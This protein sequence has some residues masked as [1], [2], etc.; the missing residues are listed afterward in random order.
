MEDGDT[1]SYELSPEAVTIDLGAT[2]NTDV[3]GNTV[4]GLQGTQ[5]DEDSYA[6]G[7]I[8]VGIENVMGSDENDNITGDANA[9]RLMGG[10]GNDELTGVGGA[11]TLMGG[12]G[13]DTLTGGA[14]DDKLMGGADDDILV[15]G[16]GNDMFYGGA[17]EDQM[18]AASGDTDIF[19][20]SPED[21]AGHDIINSF[22]ANET[23]TTNRIDLRAF[24]LDEDDLIPLI[25]FRGGSVRIDLRPFGGGTIEVNGAGSLDAV[26]TVDA[27]G[28]LTGLSVWED[29]NGDNMVTGEDG[30]FIL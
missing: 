10:D 25:S 12:A 22:E 29:T 13:R 11:N 23:G 8:L 27:N 17:G 28:D 3:D 7:D 4:A 24:G 30:I 21:G 9:N 14:G 20:F 2:T 15:G 26:G 6:T 5:G 19:I 1:V 16:G 18:T